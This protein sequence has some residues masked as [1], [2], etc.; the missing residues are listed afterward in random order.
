MASLPSRSLPR[1]VSPAAPNYPAR[2]TG[3]QRHGSGVAFGWATGV[4]QQARLTSTIYHLPRHATAARRS[5][6]RLYRYFLSGG[7]GEGRGSSRAGNDGDMADLLEDCTLLW[8]RRGGSS[9]AVCRRPSAGVTPAASCRREGRACGRRGGSGGVT[10]AAHCLLASG[11]SAWRQ[12][13]LAEP[14]LRC[15]RYAARLERVATCC[16]LPSRTQAV[17]PC[18]LYWPSP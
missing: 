18:L 5:G 2:R 13:G 4:E 15:A 17:L 10:C 7:T 3:R 11:H 1:S 12:T 14:W 9:A 6:S 8:A 16:L